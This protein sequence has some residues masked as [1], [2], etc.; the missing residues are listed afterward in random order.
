MSLSAQLFKLQKTLAIFSCSN[1]N[2]SRL[3]VITNLQE[4]F[5]F[6]SSVDASRIRKEFASIFLHHMFTASF[7][8]KLQD[9]RALCEGAHHV[10]LSRQTDNRITQS[11]KGKFDQEVFRCEWSFA[12]ESGEE[13][14][15][16]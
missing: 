15:E 9:T 16:F 8:K 4:M 13:S 14:G 3:Y 12:E 2:T 11:I 10:I 6:N 1:A 5:G 7:V